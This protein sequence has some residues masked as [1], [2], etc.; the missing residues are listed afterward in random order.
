MNEKRKQRLESLL[1][2]EIA[3]IV[4]FEI[5]KPKDIPFITVSRVMLSKDG[6][7]AQ[8]FISSLNQKDAVRTVSLLNKASKHIQHLLGKR[9]RIKFIPKL[10]FTVELG[11]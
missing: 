3:D 6:R 8:V 11:I 10:E 1:K 2:R 4:Q 5:D 9:I 7:K